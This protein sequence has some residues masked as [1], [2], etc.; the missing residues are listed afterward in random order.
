MEEEKARVYEPIKRTDGIDWMDLNTFT[1]RSFTQLS[2]G[3]KQRVLIASALA[4]E[5]NLLLLDEPTS[6]LDL[7][8]QQSIYRRLKELSLNE[9]KT[10]VI[11]THDINLAAQFCSRLILLNEGQITKDGT[12]DD[13]LKFPT[14]EEVYGVQVYIDVNPFTDSIYILP[15][16]TK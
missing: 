1:D 13:V 11:V 3:E 7:K 2:G 14:I 15:F 12:P 9:G 4:Q 16:D 8:H 5:P 10:I 6:A